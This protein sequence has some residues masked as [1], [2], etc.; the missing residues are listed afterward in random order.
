MERFV[1]AISL[2]LGF[3]ASAAAQSTTFV[4]I[5]DARPGVGFSAAN[6]IAYAPN[7]LSVGLEYGFDTSTYLY[8]D[9]RVTG[10]AY[11]RPTMSDTLAFTAVA[12]PG[13]VITGI[14]YTELLFQETSRSG[15]SFASS[16][17]VVNGVATEQHNITGL[18]AAS[19]PVSLSTSLS[20][21]GAAAQYL[22]GWFTVT[23]APVAIGGTQFN[24]KK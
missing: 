21:A 11:F 20:S 14:Q 3:A 16:Q 23:L 6:S 19:V 1:T 7:V 4:N 22:Q 12:P 17:L 18:Y 8:R 9:F 2:V 13:Y 15:R 10:V 24:G 5:S